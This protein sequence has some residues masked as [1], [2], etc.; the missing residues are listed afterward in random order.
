MGVDPQH[1]QAEKSQNAI[2]I[3]IILSNP[4]PPNT[5]QCN[6]P[7]RQT[8]PSKPTKFKIPSRIPIPSPQPPATSLPQPHSHPLS[9]VV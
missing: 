8:N 5:M 6:E 3:Q 9:V 7:L 4:I 2:S 1:L